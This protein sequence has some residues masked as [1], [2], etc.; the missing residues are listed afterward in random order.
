MARARTSKKTIKKTESGL[1]VID[2][3]Q[4]RAD[5]LAEAVSDYNQKYIQKP[6][7]AAKAFVEDLKDDPGKA[8]EN[9]ID[10]GKD[11]L[12]EKREDARQLMDD[13]IENGKEIFNNILM[14]DKIE[15]KVTSGLKAV[16]TRLNFPSKKDM[17]KLMRTMRELNK[18]VDLL[19]KKYS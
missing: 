15:K 12:E 10:E 11:Y 3:I 2:G 19:N 5:D 13:F 4:K 6:F 1:S 8:F 18:K 17:E 7:K 14:L 16:P 9:L